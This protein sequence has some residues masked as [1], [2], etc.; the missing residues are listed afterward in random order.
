[1]SRG[2]TD[3]ELRARLRDFY[4]DYAHCLDDRNL[5]RWTSFFTEDAIY[6]VIARENHDRGLEHATIYCDGKAMILDRALAVQKTTVQAP[7]WLR[8][9]V[10]GVRIRSAGEVIRSEASFIICESLSDRDPRLFLVGRY[11]DQVVRLR[12]SFLFKE[13]NCVYDN[14]RILNSLIFPP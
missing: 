12:D 13:R 3:R 1:M 2:E 6:R 14:Y 11:V 7:R 9:V 10:G 8:H 5:D 4:D